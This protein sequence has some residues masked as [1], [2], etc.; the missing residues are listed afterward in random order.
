[1]KIE[2]FVAARIVIAGIGRITECDPRHQPTIAGLQVKL[3]P[4]RCTVSVRLRVIGARDFDRARNGR[5]AR[6]NQDRQKNCDSH[7]ANLID[8]VRVRPVGQELSKINSHTDCSGE[9]LPATALPELAAARIILRDHDN[10]ALHSSRAQA[11]QT[12]IK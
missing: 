4:R 7:G 9:F 11:L 2:R 5:S 6:R 10:Y 3:A 12:F 8:Y 1:M